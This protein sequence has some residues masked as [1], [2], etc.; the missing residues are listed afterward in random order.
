MSL[1]EGS[2]DMADCCEGSIDT[3]KLEANQRRV[4]IIVMIINL[5]TF[6][7]MVVA[8]WLSH[9]S[10]LLSGT[11]DNLGD[12]L[13][14]A[15]SLAVVGASV[16]AKARV[17]LFKGLL[18]SAAAI[19][20]AVQI[21]W[22]LTHME[23]PVVSTMGIA[24]VLNLCA[25]VVCLTLLTPHR[26]DDVNMS[27]VWECSRNDVAEGLAVIATVGAVWLTDSAWPDL[28]VATALLFM[29]SRSAFRVLG[30]AWSELRVAHAP[31]G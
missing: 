5:V 20:V 31:A 30:N 16:A 19:A 8:S 21:G 29:F 11:L 28:V 7:G 12:A 6:A 24:A 3:A 9:S 4:L 25:N 2:I 15:M 13:T 18:I 26:H 10:A 17:A 27:S 1:N 22:R 14:Y 23:V